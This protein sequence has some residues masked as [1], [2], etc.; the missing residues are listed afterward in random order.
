MKLLIDTNVLYG[1]W[2]FSHADSRL[3]LQAST[4]GQID[5][6]VPEVVLLEAASMY[7]RELDKTIKNHETLRRRLRAMGVEVAAV[8]VDVDQTAAEY[9]TRLRLRLGNAGVRTPPPPDI[10][11]LDVIRRAIAKRKP[12]DP[13]G[14]GYRDS[15]IWEQVLAEAVDD[16]VVLVTDNW[17][18]FASGKEA[19]ETLAPELVEELT[20]AGLDPNRVQLVESLRRAVS[21]HVEP[22][23]EALT[24]I[25]A[26]L[27][28]RGFLSLL[29]E[30][31]NEEM[32]YRTLFS[33]SDRL[34]P[35]FEDEELRR[36]DV[37]EVQ[38]FAVEELRDV[39]I[40]EAYD[41]DSGIAFN[42]GAV[43]DAEVEFFIFKYEIASVDEA[44]G[45]TIS[46]PDWNE[47]MMHASK[48]MELAIEG[49]GEYRP[50]EH[51]LTAEVWLAY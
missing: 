20:L 50:E 2:E 27:E 49:V 47:S 4:A 48:T 22:S 45:V 35:T 14:R 3:L 19:R 42:F 44:S 21:L 16:E 13:N 23:A 38:V 9:E 8:G 30:A 18:D 43:I 28:D 1:N 6:I 10:S 29:Y 39:E 12:F 37:D 26:L 25:R 34:A 41:V 24:R 46:D 40:D 11:H 15:L 7:R 36:L 33:D 31:V 32:L 5:L 51:T 17:R